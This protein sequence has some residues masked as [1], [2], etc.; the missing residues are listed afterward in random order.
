MERWPSRSREAEKPAPSIAATKYRWFS[1]RLRSR[2]GSSV[3]ISM[4]SLT[5]AAW[6]GGSVDV[7]PYAEQP[8][9]R[10][11]RRYDSVAT[12]PPMHPYALLSVSI[13]MMRGLSRPKYSV[14][15]APVGP[16][17]P[18]PCASST[19]TT[20]SSARRAPSCRGAKD[21]RPC[22]L[23]TPS[24]HDD[25][26][27]RRRQCELSLEVVHVEVL[28]RDR[29]RARRADT[30][31]QAQIVE[32]VRRKNACFQAVVGR[33]PIARARCVDRT[34]IGNTPRLVR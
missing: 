13:V 18:V 8:A 14:V 20:A 2:S 10:S 26:D 23:N 24:V 16:N 27:V 34:S 9:W 3:T 32:L 15:P 21:V 29:R 19:Y 12:N 25:A 22:W 17:T 5:A 11:V 28:V 30:F 6:S 33:Y 7:N 31:A 4:A 1:H